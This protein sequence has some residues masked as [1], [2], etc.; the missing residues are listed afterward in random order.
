VAKQYNLSGEQYQ[1]LLNACP[2]NDKGEAL[3]MMCG[4]F[5]ARAVDHDHACCPGKTSCGKCVR[6]LLDTRCNVYLGHIRDNSSIG[7]ILAEYLQHPP[8]QRI[9][10]DLSG[11]I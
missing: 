10:E 11:A 8:A 9:L 3:C 7:Y 5:K 6:G 2:K 1:A 4:R